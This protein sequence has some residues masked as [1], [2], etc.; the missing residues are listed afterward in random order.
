MRQNAASHATDADEDNLLPPTNNRLLASEVQVP[1]LA[2]EF[3]NHLPEAS[4]GR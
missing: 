1:I 4:L 3:E 2:L